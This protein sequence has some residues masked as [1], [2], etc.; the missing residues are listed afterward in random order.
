[1][2]LPVVI[3]PHGELLPAVLDDAAFAG[4]ELDDAGD[5]GGRLAPLLK[6]SGLGRAGA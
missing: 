1:M 6:L 3:L 2:R 5:A 4:R